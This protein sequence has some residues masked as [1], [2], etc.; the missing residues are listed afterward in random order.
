[1]ASQELY[2]LHKEKMNVM[3][4]ALVDLSLRFL[5]SSGNFLPHGATLSPDGELKL[6]AAAPP[7][8]DMTTSEDV[9]ALLHNGLRDLVRNS[10]ASA[11][12]TAENVRVSQDGGVSVDA[13]KVLF[14]NPE[15]LCVAFYTP[16]RKKMFGGYKT[17]PTFANEAPPEIVESWT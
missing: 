15:G 1:M 4:E 14:E 12:A 3:V 2:A 7:G 8:G 13:I 5:G 10:E 16:F 17:D 11:V 9:L 6:V